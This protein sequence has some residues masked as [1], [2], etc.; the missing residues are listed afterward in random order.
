MTKIYSTFKTF[1]YVI[2][3]AA[4]IVGNIAVA[5]FVPELYVQKSTTEHSEQLRV[6]YKNQVSK[7]F[8]IRDDRSKLCLLITNVSQQY[9]LEPTLLS[10]PCTS[11]ILQLIEEQK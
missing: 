3:F 6:H 8:Y 4:I 9:P 10:V 2:M 7:S 1:P 11:E 5:F